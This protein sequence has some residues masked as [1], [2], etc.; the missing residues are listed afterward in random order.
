MYHMHKYT[1]GKCK[2]EQK[3]EKGLSDIWM[4]T[5]VLLDFIFQSLTGLCILQIAS[6][7]RK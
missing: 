6:E 1:W 3:E 7:Y 5:T 4:G 2:N